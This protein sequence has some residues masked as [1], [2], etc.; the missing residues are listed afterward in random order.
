M[1]A[2]FASPNVL[3]IRS[4][5]IVSVSPST[6]V[7]ILEATGAERDENGEWVFPDDTR[8]WLL[9]EALAY[10]IEALPTIVF[11]AM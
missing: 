10:A 3:H 6:T 11:D 5:V 2:D 1:S 4:D 8:Y 9:E 7:A